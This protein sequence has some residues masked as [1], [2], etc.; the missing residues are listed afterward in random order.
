MNLF[1]KVYVLL[2]VALLLFDLCF[3]AVKN[4]KKYELFPRNPKLEHRIRNE[5]KKYR[6]LGS[7]SAGFMAEMSEHLKKT[8]N[9]ITLQTVLEQE[10]DAVELFRM[11]IYEL[12]DIYQKKSD[13]EQAYYTYVISTMCDD[14]EEW[15]SGFAE[16]FLT[17][18]D[19]K[20]LYTFSNTMNALYR[21]GQLNLILIAI[22]KADSRGRFYHKKLLI[23]GILASAVD[24]EKLTE[25]LTERFDQYS[26][27]IQ[28]CLLDIFRM[29]KG[30]ASD[31]CFRLMSD[32]KTNDEVRYSAMR[33]FV[34][35]PSPESREFFFGLLEKDDAAWI[36]Q[37]LAVQALGRYSDKKVYHKIME[38]AKKQEILVV[39]CDDFGV[40]G[41]VRIAYC[42]SKERIVNSL[43]AFKALAESYKK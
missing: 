7:F 33:Y 18:L 6:E 16:R 22:D 31:L 5:I 13:Y 36:E 32:Q 39:P 10:R 26:P 28:E 30:N 25:E 41:Y 23:D 40:K 4:F 20:S 35:Y 42:V 3:L 9:L 24:Q 21:L 27:N 29:G 11:M 2:C 12:I 43:P 15:P 37:M 19:S 1:I 14:G 17:F 8:K 38:K 34:K